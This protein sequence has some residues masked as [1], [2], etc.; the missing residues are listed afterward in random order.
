MF[1]IIGEIVVA[2]SLMMIIAGCAT[3]PSPEE[4]ATAYYG[5]YPNEYESI[6]KS[7]MAPVLRDAQ[8]AIYK[9]KEP[10][11]GYAYKWVDQNGNDSLSGTV[12]Y[13]WVVETSINAKN[14]FGGYTGFEQINFVIRDNRVVIPVTSKYGGISY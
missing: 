8:S 12:E 1:K 3:T 6:I 2:C 5:P 13:G 10:Y 9:F 11:K 14:A 4:L 7:F